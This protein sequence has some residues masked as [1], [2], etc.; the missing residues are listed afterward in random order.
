MP[1]EEGIRCS[2]TVMPV[3]KS[4]GKFKIGFI[5]RAK[6]DSFPGMLVAPGGKVE[7]KDGIAIHGVMYFSVEDCAV[8]ELLEEC[9]MRIPKE[10]LTYFCGLTLPNGRVV[11][12]F[13]CI[14]DREPRSKGLIYFTEEET[15]KRKDFAPGM[16]SEA[17]MLFKK[18]RSEKKGLK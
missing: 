1:D 2:V 10:K 5:R 14:F 6:N 9:R 15:R 13:Y 11:I 4:G 16:E 3:I 8:R 18:L 12:S 17:L 7:K